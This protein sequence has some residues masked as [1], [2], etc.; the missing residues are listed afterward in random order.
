MATPASWP[1]PCSPSLKFREVQAMDSI[2]RGA[3]PPASRLTCVLSRSPASGYSGRWQAVCVEADP[4]LWVRAIHSLG[5]FIL[6][7]DFSCTA[8]VGCPAILRSGREL[9]QRATSASVKNRYLRSPLSNV[10]VGATLT[11]VGIRRAVGLERAVNQQR[12]AAD[13]RTFYCYPFEA[14]ACY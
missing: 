12:L 8:G 6:F 13:R 11:R 10:V 9:C 7:P 2:T 3:H 5:P 4:C 14:L 1:A